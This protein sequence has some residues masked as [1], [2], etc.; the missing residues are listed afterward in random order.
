M[1]RSINLGSTLDLDSGSPSVSGS[2]NFASCEVVN[3]LGQCAR[4]N[5]A[6]ETEL[7]NSTSM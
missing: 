2:D 1:E 7:L 3:P 4:V 5:C 6:G